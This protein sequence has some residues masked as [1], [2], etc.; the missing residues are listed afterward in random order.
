MADDIPFVV[1]DKDTVEL[2]AN[3]LSPIQA[4]ID[5]AKAEW[6]LNDEDTELLLSTITAG[7]HDALLGDDALSDEE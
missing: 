4:R 6:Q 2:E 5:E 1:T 3:K 7:A